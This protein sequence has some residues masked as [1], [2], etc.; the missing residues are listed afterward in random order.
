MAP[1]SKTVLIAE[2]I[3][4][5]KERSKPRDESN[6]EDCHDVVV[7]SMVA[8]WIE[9]WMYVV[10]NDK[11]VSSTSVVGGRGLPCLKPNG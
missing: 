11:D 5:T 10:Q 3:V 9:R 6:H 4:P 2:K 7:D 1:A 8:G